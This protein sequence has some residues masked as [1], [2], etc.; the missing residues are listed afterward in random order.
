M[1]HICGDNVNER[2]TVGGVPPVRVG[3]VVRLERDV[4]GSM[5]K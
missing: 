4:G 5:V 2:P 1:Q 3:T